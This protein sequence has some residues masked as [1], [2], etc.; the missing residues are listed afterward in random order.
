MNRENFQ[1]LM[2]VMAESI[3]PCGILA[4]KLDALDDKGQSASGVF[5]SDMS[6]EKHLLTA[7]LLRLNYLIYVQ[8]LADKFDKPTDQMQK[9]IDE[10]ADKI[11]FRVDG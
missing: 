1:K 4:A 11:K 7:A 10:T 6:K 2:R 5:V 8:G 3:A 9:M